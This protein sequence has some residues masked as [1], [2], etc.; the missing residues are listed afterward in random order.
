MTQTL[1]NKLQKISA[2]L[3]V[4][5][6]IIRQLHPGFKEPL[7]SLNSAIDL[8]VDIRDTLSLVDIDSGTNHCNNSAEIA[9]LALKQREKIN[10]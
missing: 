5:E 1:D 4:A 9:A 6:G 8:V 10:G 2:A 3:T 7:K